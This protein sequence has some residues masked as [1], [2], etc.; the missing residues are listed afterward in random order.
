MES[1]KKR[2][3]VKNAAIIFLVILLL[4]TFFSNTI[5]NYSLPEVSAQ[6]VTSG[7]LSEQIRGSVNVKAAES[8]EMKLT[9]TRVIASVHFKQGDTI[10]KGDIIITLE[11]KESTELQTAMNEL[12]TLKFDYEKMLVT[13]GFDYSQS[14]LEIANLEEDIRLAKADLPNIKNYQNDYEAAQQATADANAEVKQLTKKKTDIDEQ[15]SALAAGNYIMMSK[16]YY[17]KFTEAENKI[18]EAEK[19]KTG[20][21]DKVKALE[22]EAAKNT[23]TT[24]TLGSAKAAISSAQLSLSTYQ[25]TYYNALAE[26][27]ATSQMLVDIQTA[28][29]ALSSAQQTYNNLVNDSLTGT[30]LG[31]NLKNA[32]QTQ[33]NA[34]T[35]YNN[36]KQKLDKLKLE[37]SLELKK[38][39]DY[40]EEKLDAANTVLEKAKADEEKAKTKAETT[41]EVAEDNIKKQERDLEAK[42]AA[43]RTQQ[44]TDMKTQG[45]ADIDLKAKQDAIDKKT[46]EVEKLRSKATETEIKAQVGGVIDTMNCTAGETLEP[47]A[48]FATIQMTEKGYVATLIVTNEQ[49]RKVSVGDEATVENYWYGDATAKLTAIKADTTNP[50]QNKVLEFTLNG[51]ITPGTSLDI[52]IG[53]KGKYYDIIVPSNAIREDSNGKFV[54]TVKAKSTPLGNRYIAQR[55]AVT[56][57]ASNDKLTAVSGEIIQSDFIITTATK[58]VDAGA[59]VRLVDNNG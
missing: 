35:Q 31:T 19:F 6:Y 1:V 59:Q 8:Y 32:Q 33:T 57:L 9:E 23:V 54:L 21:D 49:S 48:T 38:Q 12:D 56:V 2:E 51:D 26:G 29:D 14:N 41:V 45:T 25:Q 16:S 28:T 18:T 24:E 20:A 50:S 58:P 42:K 52:S 36:A 5:M 15:V 10:N 27:K 17:D 47:N 3:W 39:G 46:E 30:Q 44:T 7:N 53:G 37:I 22:S 55:V 4:L 13:R 40:Y 11:D 43:L 34:V